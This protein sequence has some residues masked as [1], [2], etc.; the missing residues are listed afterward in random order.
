VEKIQIETNAHT[1][2]SLDKNVRGARRQ[3]TQGQRSSKMKK[4]ECLRQGGKMSLGK[5]SP[6]RLPSRF[7]SI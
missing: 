1:K 2:T 5:K 7:L 4:M 3:R 6:E